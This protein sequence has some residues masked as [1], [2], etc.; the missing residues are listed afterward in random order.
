MNE[1]DYD[2]ELAEKDLATRV[3]PQECADC[4]APEYIPGGGW[5][6]KWEYC[7][8]H[9]CTATTA[10]GERCKKP[11]CDDSPL[12]CDQHACVASWTIGTDP[13][14]IRCAEAGHLRYI[15]DGR[16]VRICD[17]HDQKINQPG[18]PGQD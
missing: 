11:V 7:S 10:R 17:H 1:L 8:V 4:Q 5:R 2:F 12:C 16:R 6:G 3:S 15:P 14:R 9:R 13:G 18:Q